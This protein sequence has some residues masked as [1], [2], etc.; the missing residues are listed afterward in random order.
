[1]EEPLIFKYKT[2]II[3][4]ISKETHFQ[5]F[6]FQSL[7]LLSQSLAYLSEISCEIAITQENPQCSRFGKVHSNRM[8]E[9]VIKSHP[10]TN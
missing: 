7:S 10:A 1:L 6:F 8:W 3:A 9:S 5:I 2:F 4:H